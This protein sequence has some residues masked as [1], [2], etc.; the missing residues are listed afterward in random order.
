MKLAAWFLRV[1]GPMIPNMP[2][3]NMQEVIQVIE[4]GFVGNEPL[5]VNVDEGEAGE[6]VRVYIG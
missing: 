3:T 5:I 2:K 6:H 4:T 1:F